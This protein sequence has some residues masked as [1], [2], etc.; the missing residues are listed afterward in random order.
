M[1]AP[2]VLIVLLGLFHLNGHAE[3]ILH[4]NDATVWGQSQVIKGSFTGFAPVRG[5]LSLNRERIPFA[6]SPAEGTFSVTVTLAEGVN[7]LVAEADSGGTTIRSDTL[8]LSLGYR[9]R[10]RLFAW[11]TAPGKSIRLHSR[12]MENPVSAPLSYQWQADPGNPAAVNL[13]TPGDS[14]TL[15]TIN[16]D[17]LPGEYYFNLTAVTPAGDTAR[18]RTF[19]TL[20]QSGIRPFRIETDH[21]AWIDEAIL[22]EITP[23]SFVQDGRLADIT[24][25]I[26]ELAELGVTA[27]W[28]QPTFGTLDFG[29]MGYGITDYFTVRSD[30]GDEADLRHLVAT[31]HAQGLRVLLDMVPN[32]SH[33]RHPYALDAV[34]FGTCSHYYDFY[35]RSAEVLPEVPYSQYYNLHAQGFVYYFWEELPNLDYDN[36]EVRRWMTEICTYW[37]RE[38]DIDGYRF[39]AVWGVN[40]RRPDYTRELRLALKEIKP[41]LLMLAED[42]APSARVFDGRFDLAFDWSA[43][44]GWVSQWSWQ[45]LYHDY[46][47]DQYVTIFNSWQPG[48]SLRLR[49]ALTNSG[50]GFHPRAKILRFLENNDSQR[51]ARHHTPEMTRMAAALE[52][53]LHGVPLLYNGQ[54]IGFTG[55][56]PYYGEAIFKKGETIRAQDSQGLFYYYQTLIRWRK[57]L[58]ALTS[59][60]FAELPISPSTYMFAFRRWHE[61][62]N[63][64]VLLNMG[65]RAENASVNLPLTSLNLDST[66]T[67]YLTEL[68]SGE[69]LLVKPG[70]LEN[71]NV[72]MDKYNARI[73]LLADT[74]TVTG[75]RNAPHA[76]RPEFMA[77]QQ[78]YPNP[79]NP[80]TTIRFILNWSGHVRL[81]IY[82]IKG[83][84]VAT[85]VDEQRKV[86]EYEVP[87]HGA[88]LA[89]GLYFCRLESAGLT[90]VR[91]MMVTK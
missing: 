18:A 29:G 26:P 37:V 89:S 66:K 23:C 19:I 14:T 87:F 48:R 47:Q 46:W 39:D 10:P 44:D 25:K 12:V 86:G 4:K 3:I 21:A 78:N 15:V 69:V 74:V 79:F 76:V 72:A 55:R 11:A 31:A 5:I 24:A 33:I 41:E 83:E 8:R 54:E 7:T 22:Y 90:A 30:V 36:P 45:V 70:S 56:H 34:R 68:L 82:N 59:D 1:K 51:F 9:L 58:P 13:L 67:W 81:Q 63:I 85:L 43:D 32:H 52:F 20:D 2:A 73:Y 49:N 80:S 40:A 17:G 35:Q 57:M 71:L 84:V 27:L 53:S 6:V 91:K 16:C 88:H 38:F 60:N 64:F 61:E 42:K 28:L 50:S 77:L 65:S 62:Q 75:I